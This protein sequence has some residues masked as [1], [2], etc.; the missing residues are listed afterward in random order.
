MAGVE[1]AFQRV[2]KTFPNSA[3]HILSSLAEGADRI[4]AIKFL[5]LPHASLWVPLP[6]PEDKYVEDFNTLESKQEFLRLLGKAE[7]VIRM[8][9]TKKRG[10]G[11]RLAGNYLLAN[12][13]YLVAIWDGK[14]ARGSA[15][16]GGIVA[17]AR[18]RSLPLIWIHAGNRY[19][20]TAIPTSQGVEQGRV[21]FENFPPSGRK[22]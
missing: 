4:L 13:D 1:C 6:L 20:A 2:L 12:S 14:P 10:E 16:T 17:L 5:L 15:G 3:F 9:P 18:E 11:Y 22:L 8:P 19:P 7:R 21:T